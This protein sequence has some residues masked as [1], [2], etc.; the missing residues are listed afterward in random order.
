MRVTLKQVANQAGVSY[1]TVSKVINGQAQVSKET[2]ERIWQVVRH[3][4]YRPN[5]TARSLRSKKSYTIGYSWV[6]NPLKKINPTLYQF[7][8][9]MLQAAVQ[10][11]YYLL[12]FPSNAEMEDTTSVYQDLIYTGRVDGFILSNIEYNDPRVL[13]L[14]EN[15]FP[16]VAF[17]RSNPDWEFPYIDVDG[18]KGVQMAIEHLIEQGHSKIALLGWPETSRVG[19]NRMEGYYQ[20]MKAGGLSSRPEWVLRNEGTYEYGIFGTERLL[21]LPEEIRPTGIVTL[22]DAVAVGAM[23]AVKEQGYQVGKDIG[24]IGFD[25]TPLVENLDPPLTSVRQPAWEVGE[26]VIQILLE[27]LEKE[28]VPDRVGELVDPEIVIRASSLRNP[29]SA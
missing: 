4:G 25:D 13:F 3:L 29:G 15:N 19:N 14:L 23:R 24:V 12:S 21:A 9:S 8:Q 20:A 5:Y 16:F 2:E 7:L 26:R 6:P 18:G 22:N 27:A 1:Q 10:Y 28:E 11:G 17:G